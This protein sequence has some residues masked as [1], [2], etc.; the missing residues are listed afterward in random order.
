[1]AVPRPARTHHLPWG[2]IAPQRGQK[3]WLDV[4]TETGEVVSLLPAWRELF[5]EGGSAS[6]FADP[7][8]QLAW[9]RVHRVGPP[10]VAA[11]RS[12]RGLEAVAGFFRRMLGTRHLGVPVLQPLGSGFSTQIMDVPELLARPDS[13]RAALALIVGWL[14]GGRHGWC[15]ADLSLTPAQGWVEPA[16]LAHRPGATAVHKS[17]RPQV[18]LEVEPDAWSGPLP[19]VKRNLRESLRRG[20]NRLERSGSD[21]YVDLQDDCGPHFADALADLVRL[22][23]ERSRLPGPPHQDVLAE[24]GNRELLLAMAGASAWTRLRIWRLVLGGSAIAALLTFSHADRVWVSV[25]GIGAAGWRF[26]AV[27]LLQAQ[28]VRT[29]AAEGAREVAFSLGVDTAKLRWS[30]RVRCFQ[31]FSVVPGGWGSQV[32]FGAF[33]QARGLAY[34]R[35]SRDWTASAAAIPPGPGPTGPDPTGTEGNLP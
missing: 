22:H 23:A 31:E 10:V 28:A 4:L 17:S 19:M 32:L 26:S 11:V 1:M 2:S 25:S 5:A 9:A 29:A 14:G 6:P 12:A 34:L 18:V 20:R 30:E 27:T 24:P 21:W 13:A 7:D 35:R 8:L 15:W 33:W 16:W 3:L